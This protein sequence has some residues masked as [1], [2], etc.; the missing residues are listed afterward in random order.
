[1]PDF[2]EEVRKAYEASP[3]P[4]PRRT[5][6]EQGPGEDTPYGLNALQGECDVLAGTTEGSRNHQLNIAGVKLFSLVA[7]EYLNEDTVRDNLY[8]AAIEAGLERDETLKTIQ[9]AYRFAID[10][11][12]YPADREGVSAS[13]LETAPNVDIK[14]LLPLV[15]WH[16]LW[17]DDE[18]EEWIIDPLLP[19]RRLI[20]LYSA[21]KVGKSL[22]MLE[23]AVAISNGTQALGH[24][25]DRP[26]R[27]L[28]VDFENDPRGDV[29]SRLKAMGHG[30]DDLQGLC[31]LSFPTLAALDT[32]RGAQEL[33]AAVKAYD[34][35]VVVIDTV[36]RS[37]EGDENENDTWL[38][39]YRHTGLR[40]KQAQVALIRL[41]HTGKDET[42]GQR[43]AS[44]KEGDVDAVWRMSRVTT[45]DNAPETFRLTCT[46]N[47][48]PIAPGDKLITLERIETPYLHHRVNA[49]G[50]RDAV[51][52]E[53]RAWL[54]SGDVDVT[55]DVR[56]VLWPA[57]KAAGIQ[58]SHDRVREVVNQLRAVDNS[59]DED[60]S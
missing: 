23:I 50:A 14:D 33:L 54:T 31:Y 53:L 43:G 4:P 56:R 35:E 10:K 16:A 27:V 21:P 26:R 3:D 29:R 19:A 59:V 38:G 46:H 52:A 30:P 49:M 40:L 12:R 39:F 11:P 51:T 41:D 42:K 22:L 28:Y 34:C 32:E 47:R 24:I 8:N 5:D 60:F 58:A 7:S 37:V 55:Q 1:M 18:E 9:S 48:F 6:G 36:S 25:M 20:A 57:A 13:T 17:A 44:A 45:G 15:D 2:L